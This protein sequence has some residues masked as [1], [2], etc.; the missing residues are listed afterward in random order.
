MSSLVIETTVCH[1][2]Y[3]V[4]DATD[5]YCRHCGTPTV[6]QAALS[7]GD[8]PAASFATPPAFAPRTQPAKLSESPWVVLPLMFLVL[9]PFGLPLLWRSRRFTLLW[10]GVLT[11]IMAAVTVFF[12][13]SVWFSLHQ[14]LAPLQELDRIRGL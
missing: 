5:N 12:L 14:M 6:I 7:E 8:L 11:A 3:A 4:L 13:W 2:C 9:G 1:G 10:K